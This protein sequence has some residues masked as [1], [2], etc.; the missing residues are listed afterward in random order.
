M[1]TVQK[2]ATLFFNCDFPKLVTFGELFSNLDQQVRQSLAVGNH[3]FKLHLFF[4]RALLIKLLAKVV[5]GDLTMCMVQ[6]KVDSFVVSE[7]KQLDVFSE[8]LLVFLMI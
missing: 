7:W 5:F 3:F 4:N 2:V 1:T 6:Q 8:I